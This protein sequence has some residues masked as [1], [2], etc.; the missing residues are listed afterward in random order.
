MRIR[1]RSLLL[2]GA[3]IML[4]AFMDPFASFRSALGRSTVKVGLL[5][6]LSGKTRE[7]GNAVR[8]VSEMA[9]DRVNA[10]GG[11]SGRLVEL[12]PLDT[13]GN[14]IV[15]KNGAKVLTSDREV[16]AVV[17]PADWA[18]AM[19]TKP[20]F[21]ETQTPVM[22]LTWEDSVIRGGKFGMYEWI[23]RL[24]L[25]RRTA[26]ERIGTF[27]KNKGWTRVG[28]VITSDGIGRE[29][30]EWF[31]HESPDYG[32][33]EVIVKSFI[34]TEDVAGKLRML[35][36]QKPQVI[37]SWCPATYAVTVARILREM[38]TDLPLFQCHEISPRKYVEMAGPDAKKTLFVSNKILVWE[39][40]EETDPQK[41]MIQDFVHQYRD[42]YGYGSREP[43]SPFMGYV[44][45][46]IMILVRSMRAGGTDRIWLQ[47]VIESTQ[48]HVG[49]GGVYGFN[50]EDHNGLDPDSTVIVEVDRVYG[51]GRRWVG[52][53]R[54]VN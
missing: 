44:W 4:L 30:R 29:A 2:Q 19:M 12:I 13:A 54:L 1:R 10:Q 48:R 46:S 47:H 45:D 21:E 32:V 40:L 26:L 52:S 34:L 36:D 14:P 31:E 53:W 35:V 15:G 24:P 5:V 49:I 3:L 11:V 8:R 41:E 50:H 6:D 9:V 37:V 7:K 28:L 25:R 42:V 43:V 39:E 18:T 23:F 17:G 38:T 51:D 22:M 16:T 33:E 27:L 20:F